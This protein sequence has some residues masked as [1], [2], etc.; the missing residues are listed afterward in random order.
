MA[1]LQCSKCKAGIHYHGEPEGIEYVLIKIKD[2]EVITSS[3]FAPDKKQYYPGSKSPRLFASDSIEMDFP[4]MI[5]TAWKCPECGSLMFFGE[6]G[7]VSASFEEDMDA[8]ITESS[9]G[10]LY[11]IFD[12]YAWDALTESALPDWKIPEQFRPVSYVDISDES[13]RVLSLDGNVRKQ[14]KRLRCSGE[15]QI[16]A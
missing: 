15:N 10:D 6:N 3:K 8:P 2:W 7:S 11:V 9:V 13:I 5:A 14:Y 4:E 16:Q 1:S 12:D